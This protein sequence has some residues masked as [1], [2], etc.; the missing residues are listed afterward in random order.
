[1]SGVA[2]AN[3]GLFQCIMDGW[4][5]KNNRDLKDAGEC[6]GELFSLFFDV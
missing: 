6:S 1:M 5:Y 4:N 2:V 3:W